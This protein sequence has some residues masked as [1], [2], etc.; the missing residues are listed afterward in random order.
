MLR[1]RLSLVRDSALEWSLYERIIAEDES[2]NRAEYPIDVY[3][4]E[5][6]T[7]EEFHDWIGVGPEGEGEWE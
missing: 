2:G 7:D 3:G 1:E 5:W 4:V 6:I